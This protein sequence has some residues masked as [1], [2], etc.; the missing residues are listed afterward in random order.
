MLRDNIEVSAH[1]LVH[2]IQHPESLLKLYKK[3]QSFKAIKTEPYSLYYIAGTVIKEKKTQINKF[4][5][6][7]TAI[8]I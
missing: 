7:S 8:K 2:T 6:L 3:E 5:T 4:K 1:Y